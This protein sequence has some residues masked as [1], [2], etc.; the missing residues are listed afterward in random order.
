VSLGVLF[1]LSLPGLVCLLVVLA[2]VERLGRWGNSRAVL[3]WRRKDAPLAGTG[4]EE[5]HALLSGGKRLE[6]EERASR[7]LM[8]D[9]EG[10]GAPGLTDAQGRAVRIVLP[11]RASPS[12]ER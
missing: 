1:A 2:A 5:L 8:R 3:P 9:E 6:V 12:A 10:D 7:S 4:L 11:G